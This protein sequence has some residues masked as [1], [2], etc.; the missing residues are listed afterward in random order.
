VSTYFGTSALLRLHWQAI[1]QRCVYLEIE[2]IANDG[3]RWLSTKKL[4]VLCGEQSAEVN[5][6]HDSSYAQISNRTHNC[7]AVHYR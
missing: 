6:G 5:A 3:S 1:E 4:Y 7:L 2:A